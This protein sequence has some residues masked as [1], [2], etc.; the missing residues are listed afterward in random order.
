M[1]LRH[2]IGFQTKWGHRRQQV[3]MSVTE[4]ERRTNFSREA[5]RKALQEALAKNFIQLVEAGAFDRNAAQRSLAAIYGARWRD[6]FT[7]EREDPMQKA[8]SFE[9]AASE[10]ATTPISYPNT[11][12]CT[13]DHSEKLHGEKEAVNDRPLRKVA[14][15]HSE[16]LHGDHSEKLHDIKITENNT[17]SKEQQQ[18]P[19]KEKGLSSAAVAEDAN[20][21]SETKRLLLSQGFDENVADR[22]ISLYSS[23]QIQRQCRWIDR[24]QATRNRLGLLRKA[25]EEDWQEPQGKTDE[26][27]AI[28][29]PDTP[30]AHF[31][32]HFYAG[33]AGNPEPPIAPPSA[34]DIRAAKSFVARLLQIIPD[35][36]SVRDWGRAF[37]RFVRE[38]EKENPR[39]LRALTVAFRHHGDAFF[40]Q[41]RERNRRAAQQTLSATR[42]THESRFQSAYQNYLRLQ[43]ER[44]RTTY[45]QVYTEFTAQEQAERRKYDTGI[46]ANSKSI[47][48]A[49]LAN[50]DR[51][52]DHLERFR[53]FFQRE[54]PPCVLSF[55]E[56]DAQE[57]PEPLRRD[58]SSQ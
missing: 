41:F 57:N 1:I 32:A 52:E 14:R 56:W 43:D 6:G 55:W 21:F 44:I 15:D 35:Q 20:A 10:S 25:I 36:E 19:T 5:V 40:L 23:D 22:L 58:A 11:N 46:F 17:S 18:S 2:T 27:I 26:T 9:Q 38:A 54:K 33:W 24:R 42:Q 31:A 7:G 37:G 48:T 50:F 28:L 8:L 34:N 49:I 29:C 30:G 45:P 39:P 47:R 3:K 53:A 16:K 51:E 13:T 4:L 12:T